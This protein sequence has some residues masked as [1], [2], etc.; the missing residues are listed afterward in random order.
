MRRGLSAVAD[1]VLGKG[2]YLIDTQQRMIPDHM[3]WHARPMDSWWF[4]AYAKHTAEIER[5][6]REKIQQENVEKEK[7]KKMMITQEDLSRTS[8]KEVEDGLRL[9]IRV[10]MK[11]LVLKFLED[12]GGSE[13]EWWVGRYIKADPSERRRDRFE[14]NPDNVDD[15]GGYGNDGEEWQQWRLSVINVNETWVTV[16]VRLSPSCIFDVSFE[17]RFFCPPL[18]KRRW[19]C[20]LLPSLPLSFVQFSHLS[21]LLIQAQAVRV[22]RNVH[23]DNSI[24]HGVVFMPKEIQTDIWNYKKREVPASITPQPK[25]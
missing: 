20:Q 7:M 4:A 16:R 9:S 11:E 1:R 6:A 22:S 12:V 15:G 19:H 21:H 8:F 23:R 17:L 5:A 10:Q 3:H 18:F 13:G 24:S 14:G 25:L 2:G